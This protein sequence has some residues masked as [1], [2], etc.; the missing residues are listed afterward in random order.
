MS[1]IAV[2]FL[3]GRPLSGL[4]VTWPLVTHEFVLLC[5]GFHKGFKL[6]HEAHVVPLDALNICL[7]PLK[8]PRLAHLLHL[9]ISK[10]C[11]NMCFV[12][13]CPSKRRR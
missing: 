6:R 12:L 3:A 13:V 7:F 5:C 8:R 10:L 2:Q 1:C 4:L 11:L 9:G